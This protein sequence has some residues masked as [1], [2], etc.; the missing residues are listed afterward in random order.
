MLILKRAKTAEEIYAPYI[1]DEKRGFKYTYWHL[2]FVF[3]CGSFYM[4]VTLTNWFDPAA[5]ERFHTERMHH[6]CKLLL[7][8]SYC[9]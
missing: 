6:I 8:Y 7:T 5:S 9:K 3:I 4:M 2:H 1:D